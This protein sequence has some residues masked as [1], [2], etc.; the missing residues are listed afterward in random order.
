M[1][2][3]IKNIPKAFTLIELL[4]V[5]A[6]IAVLMGILLPALGKVR[7]QAW[8]TI[9]RA[10]LKTVQLGHILYMQSND[11]VTIPHPGAGNGGRGMLWVNELADNI[12][13]VD[14]ARYCPEAKAKNFNPNA[15]TGVFV[16]G[17]V[18]AP[19]GMRHPDTPPNEGYELG[20][21]TINGW[22]YSHQIQPE[23][24]KDGYDKV[25]KDSALVPAFMDGI[26][27]DT[28]PRNRSIDP[29]QIDYQG[30]KSSAMLRVLINRHGRHGNIVY[31]DGHAESV[32]LPEYFM[33][34]WN[35]TCKPNHAM[36][37]KVPTPK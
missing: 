5:I 31:F 32:Y 27:F 9:C 6:V 36:V 25:V 26:W 16:E 22:L 33:Q 1:D 28:W 2:S 3:N 30:S 8:S 24:E 29:A 10:N 34:K 11:G 23:F 20:S 21:Y 17:S 14:E 7:K 13:N 35:K 15:G 4:V 18:R 37:N 19:W 12:E